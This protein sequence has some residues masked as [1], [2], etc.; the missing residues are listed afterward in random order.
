MGLTWGDGPNSRLQKKWTLLNFLKKSQDP[1]SDGSVY[2][3][4]IKL[5]TYFFHVNMLG[6]LLGAV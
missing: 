6:H 5:L 1:L 2:G 4:P 3:F